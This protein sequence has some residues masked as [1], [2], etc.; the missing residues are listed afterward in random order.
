MREGAAEPGGG[1]D[2]AAEPDGR[3][4]GD[5][6]QLVAVRADAVDVEAHRH[7]AAVQLGLRGDGEVRALLA[8]QP[9]G[10]HEPQHLDGPAR[11]RAER[12]EVDAQ[13]DAYDRAAR[14]VGD[15]L[16]LAPG[17]V[18]GDHDGVDAAHEQ[19]VEQ[20]DRDLRRGVQAG[21]EGEHVV[22]PL[23]REQHRAD[24]VAPRPPGD[25]QEG[26]LVAELDRRRAPLLEHLGDPP[27]L[28]DQPVAAADPRGAELDDVAERGGGARV[29]GSRDDEEAPAAGVHVA[30][31][32]GAQRGAH[33]ARGRS[34]EVGELGDAHV[35]T[36]PQP[37][38]RSGG[39]AR[40]AA[41]R[42][43]A[44]RIRPV[45]SPREMRPPPVPGAV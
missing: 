1:V 38:E 26:E 16:E 33:P 2:V 45:T 42:Q 20:G 9:A 10:V 3:V 14:G 36:V 35:R 24:A 4:A 8:R 30:G 7:G 37:G 27:R 39:L 12:L 44:G 18:R 31:A 23:V 13:R 29:L 15:L 43:W 19:P 22:E 34:D 32:E 28:D 21:A 5:L 17:V 11:V 6:D 25:G 41:C 40:R